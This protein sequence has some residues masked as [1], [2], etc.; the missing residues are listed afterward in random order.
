MKK[1]FQNNYKFYNKEIKTPEDALNSD[2]R[3]FIASSTYWQVIH[4]KF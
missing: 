1:N 3:I 2:K 4:E